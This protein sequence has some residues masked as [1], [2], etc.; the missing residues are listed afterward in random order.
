[1]SSFLPVAS[2]QQQEIKAA[3]EQ[4]SQTMDWPSIGNDPLSEFTTP[5]LASVAFPVLFPDGKGDP[6]NP[7]L[8]RDINF[9][10]KIKHLIEIGNKTD[11][12]WS[13]P[14]ASHSRFPYWALNMIQ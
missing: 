3:Q 6:T 10:D 5:F 13:Y 8:M 1:M 7:Q 4:L 2:S 11:K 14:L 9:P 12:G